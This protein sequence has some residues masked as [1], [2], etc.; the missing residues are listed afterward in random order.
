MRLLRKK[1][2]KKKKKP[3]L[4]VLAFMP[5]TRTTTTVAKSYVYLKKVEQSY[6]FVG[7]CIWLVKL[8]YVVDLYLRDLST[9]IYQSI[10]QLGIKSNARP[11]RITQKRHHLTPSFMMRGHFDERLIGH[12]QRRRQ[13]ARLVVTFIIPRWRIDSRA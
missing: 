1:E 12:A 7:G 5:S 9:R 6:S 4:Y 2:L 11:S 8:L 13:N 3:K 10:N